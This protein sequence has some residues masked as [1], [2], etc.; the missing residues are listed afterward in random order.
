MASGTNAGVV[1]DVAALHRHVE[2]FAHEDAL[3]LE[4]AGAPDVAGAGDHG[5]QRA[6]HQGA[7]ADDV[8]A[9]LARQ[10][11]VVDVHDRHVGPVR[12]QQLER[13]GARGHKRVEVG[14]PAIH[15]PH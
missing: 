14:S 1:G 9:G 6:L 2:I 8:A 3:A 4:V 5:R 11:E 12:R 15:L 13:I 7:D 10:A